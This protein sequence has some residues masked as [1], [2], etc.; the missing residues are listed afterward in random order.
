MWIP[1]TFDNTVN[2]I[3][4]TITYGVTR[5]EVQYFMYV[6]PQ[7]NSEFPVTSDEWQLAYAAYQEGRV[8][9]SETPAIVEETPVEVPVV[10]NVVSFETVDTELIDL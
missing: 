1:P 7:E 8:Y 4:I 9:V 3:T 2:P 10:S 5:Q 6:T